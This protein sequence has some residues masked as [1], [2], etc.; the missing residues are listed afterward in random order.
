M[1]LRISD[2]DCASILRALSD[3]TRLRVVRLLLSRP[4][5]VSELNGFL[6]IEQSLLSH[7]LRILRDA[8]LVSTR[9]EG[10]SVRYQ[11]AREL[12]AQKRADSIDLGCCCLSFRKPSNAL[13]H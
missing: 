6:E 13:R 9:R 4:Y 10:K 2:D 5:L 11:L 1:S 3:S 7:H 8:G 12:D